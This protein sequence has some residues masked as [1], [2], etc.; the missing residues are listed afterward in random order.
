[1]KYTKNNVEEAILGLA[2]LVNLK[3]N[4]KA[5]IDSNENLPKIVELIIYHLFIYKFDYRSCTPLMYEYYNIILE[6]SLELQSKGFVNFK[7]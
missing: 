4:F 6:Y 7:K 5:I 3:T 1:M 2:E